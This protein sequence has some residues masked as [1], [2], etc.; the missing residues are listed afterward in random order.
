M[1]RARGNAWALLG[2][3]RRGEWITPL[4]TALSSL[5]EASCMRTVAFSTSPAS[6]ASW[7]FRM[8]VFSDD[9][10]DLFR[11]RRFSFC[12]LRLI[13]DLMFATRQPR[14]DSSVGSASARDEHASSL[15]EEPG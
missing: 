13:W 10:T 5:R 4:L 6:V 12:R 2:A 11:S 9:L 1:T 14:L 7:N 8:A 15:R 3:I